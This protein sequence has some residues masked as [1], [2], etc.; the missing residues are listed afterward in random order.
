[1][2]TTDPAWPLPVIDPRRCTGCGECQDYCPTAAVALNNKLAVIVD[3]Q[4][5][6]FCDRC[7]RL[8]PAEA[9][10]RTFSIQFAPQHQIRQSAPTALP[11]SPARRDR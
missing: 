2:A 10:S 5:C 4:A 3:P 9:I 8:C 7:E 11:A 1:M 6:T